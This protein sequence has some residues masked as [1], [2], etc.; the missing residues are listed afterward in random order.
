M[1]NH[2]G[3][4][5][6]A[7]VVMIMGGNPA[8]NHPIAMNW[9]RKTKERGAIVLQVDPRFNRTSHLA[10]VWARMRSGTDIAFVGGM[11]HHALAN[12]RVHWDYVRAYTTA[13]FVVKEGFAFSDGLFSGY[14]AP[15]R[16]YDK[17]TW[18]FEVDAEGRPRQDPTLRHPRCV[19]QLL[20]THFA[21]YDPDT[22]CSI[23]GTPRETYLKVCEYFTS[24][25]APDRAGTW[26]YAMGTAQHTHGTQNIRT[27]AILQLLLGNIGVA[28]GGINAMRGESNV[29]GSTDQGLIFDGLPGYLKM[30]IEADVSRPAYLKRVV[31]VAIDPKAANWWQ[32]TDKYLVSMLKAWWGAHATAA[33]DFAFAYLPKLGRG[34][35]GAGYSHI[36]LF[37]AMAAGQIKGLFCFGQNPAV[38]GPNSTLARTALDKLEWLVAADLFENE[39][40]ANWKRPGVRPA[41]VRTEVFLL[42][43]AAAV[44]KEG[45]I[46]NSGRWV[47]WRYAA[48]KPLGE[49]LPDTEILTRLAQALKR[50]Y[51]GGGVRPE[52]IVH[53]AWEY[54]E[55]GHGEHGAVHA[56]AKEING[57]FLA[58]VTT[59]D[60]VAFKAG[61]QVPTFAA[62]RA[63]GS[64]AAGNW[65]YCG[66]YTEQGNMAARRD[67]K[68][69]PNDIGLYPGWAWAW[70]ANRRILY[71]RASLSPA[72]QPW[73]PRRWVIRWNPQ[74]KKWEG[75]VPDG[76]GPP[77]A[78]QPFIM[79]TSGRADLFAPGL[80]D[81]PFPEHYEPVESP[82]KNPLSAVQF[83]PVIKVWNTPGFDLLGA[84]DRF[85][86]VATT[87]R[88]S[89]H[90]QTGAMSR[91]MPWLVG[92]MPDVFVEIGRDLAHLKKIANRDRVVVETARGRVEAY[93]LVTDR[94]QPFW[95]QGRIVHQIGVPWHWGWVGLSRGDSANLLTPN[96]GDA[97]TMIPE[98]K[99]FLCDVRKAAG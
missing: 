98:F 75:D 63:D 10:D 40:Y 25:F 99:A 37:Q 28:G 36:P 48:T 1:T 92:L 42:P 88:V 85:P 32:H 86:I 41:D 18:G 77:A 51:T 31:P 21:R 93:A 20:R 47:Q 6:N 76:G 50:A 58:D 84:P 54:A 89:E 64:T 35:Q 5:I 38:G 53:L 66:S 11:I 9:I 16:A 67:A 95:V 56:V 97:N 94:F 39:T 61:T 55:G 96:V 45:S 57:R 43:A 71:N 70:P 26:L 4:M 81:G 33:N 87:Y 52:P 83:N 8:E 34:F 49:S 79:T 12:D 72:G 22:V 60:G 23:T 65:I 14:D 80:A 44:E 69:A 7:D 30:P 27:Y 15:S 59:P 2:W 90:W 19:L 3:D 13:S 82:I 68:D 74:E 91:K 24:T 46:V 78:I 73:N 17:S 29:Q 62:L